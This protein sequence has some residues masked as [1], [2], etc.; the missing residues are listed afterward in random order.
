MNIQFFI[1][2]FLL[3]LVCVGVAVITY[4]PYSERDTS[5]KVMVSSTEQILAIFMPLIISAAT[6][7][8]VIKRLG[9]PFEVKEEMFAL[10]SIF[11][12]FASTIVVF[13]PL[14]VLIARG[15]YRS[16]LNHLNTGADIE[17]QRLL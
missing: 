3:A 13:F 5:G 4:N 10:T 15:L 11:I 12:V 14:W 9:L 8:I 6:I 16:R 7:C 17:F 2:L 1:A